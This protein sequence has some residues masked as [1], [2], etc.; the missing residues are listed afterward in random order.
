MLQQLLQSYFQKRGKADRQGQKIQHSCSKLSFLSGLFS[1]SFLIYRVIR[2]KCEGVLLFLFWTYQTTPICI[3]ST[4]LLVEYCIEFSIILFE[5]C[6][7][8]F[9]SGKIS[10]LQ[11]LCSRTYQ[12]WVSLCQRLSNPFQYGQRFK[13]C[14]SKNVYPSLALSNFL[15]PYSLKNTPLDS[16]HKSPLSWLPPNCRKKYFCL[17]QHH[18]EKLHYFQLVLSPSFTKMAS[19]ASIF[20]PPEFKNNPPNLSQEQLKGKPFCLGSLQLGNAGT[21]I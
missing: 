10:A 6:L 2:K 4:S 21:Q 1:C 19:V 14:H 5:A 17:L 7:Q 12:K 16:N 8:V 9:S 11:V 3:S 15:L 18:T 20:D 13:V